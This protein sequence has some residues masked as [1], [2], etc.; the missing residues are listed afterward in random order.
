VL[1]SDMEWKGRKPGELGFN[2]LNLPNDKAMRDR[3]VNN[4]RLASALRAS[5]MV[6]S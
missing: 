2:P 4:G 5:S 1:Y 6:S 3:E